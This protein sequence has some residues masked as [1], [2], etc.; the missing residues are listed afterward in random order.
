MGHSSE[1]IHTIL[2]AEEG[3]EVR[4][5]LGES[6]RSRPFRIEYA[7]STSDALDRV[8]PGHEHQ[9]DLVLLG[10]SW[11]ANDGQDTISGLRRLKP[12]L[13][14]IVLAEDPTPSEVVSAMR[15][16]AFDVVLR[17]VESDDLAEAMLRALNE[18]RGAASGNGA[19][20]ST[21]TK[22]KAPRVVGS[23]NEKLDLFIDRVSASDV[24]V[25][26]R[27]ETGVGKE[28][29]ARRLHQRSPRAD[30]PFLKLN[31]AA[32]PSE[33]IESE[34]FGFEKGA[35]TGAYRSMP[36]KFEL[37]DGGTILLDEIGDMDVRLQAKLLQVVQDHEFHRLGSS[38]T[39]K[40]NVR[41]MAATHCDLEQAIADGR[42]REDL[43]YRLN[44]IDIHIPPLRER[45]DEVIPL[46]EYFV[47]VY[48]TSANPALPLPLRFRQALLDHAWPGN[49]RELENVIRKYLVL[50]S[51]DEVIEG[52]KRR[53]S[54]TV[55]SQDP[56]SAT[57]PEPLSLIGASSDARVRSVNSPS[58]TNG[59]GGGAFKAAGNLEEIDNS[60]RE[61]EMSLILR[62]LE[63][64]RWNRKRAAEILKIDY[65]AL[66][67]RM[68]KLGIGESDS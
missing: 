7:D 11:Q 55:V 64:A 50:G 27:G 56:R 45:M 52:L 29:L 49:V 25:L 15:C 12:N 66:L 43:Y 31:C 28:M 13:P 36:G 17:S 32:L 18:P 61:A 35:F 9:V 33:L 51:E 46:A 53:N 21:V 68:K 8:G 34:L 59:G 67:Y 14:V 65:K 3:R 37:A 54:R 5:R 47:D 1:R 23:W 58:D 57:E 30:R 42:F 20:E 40:V 44:I 24:P 4:L 63:S 39:S 22:A 6:L 10:S 62:A 2:V 41:V 19:N 38:E 48:A 60:H 26:L 16:G